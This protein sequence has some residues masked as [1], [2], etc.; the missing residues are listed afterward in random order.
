MNTAI[1]PFR[2]LYVGESVGPDE[3]VH[4]FSPVLVANSL[5]LFQPGNVVV[6]GFTGAGKSMLLNLLSPE[7][8]LAYFESN[9]E[10]P[11]PQQFS[12]FIGAGIN[13]QTS[14]V[15]H[16]GNRIISSDNSLNESP[17]YFG[18]FLNYYVVA[19]VLNS[20]RKLS[21][22]SEISKQ[23]GID[24][25][26]AKTEVFVRKLIGSNC[27][28]DA[29]KA[30]T[31]FEELFEALSNRIATYK[32]FLNIN[33]MELPD[34][35]VKTKTIIG[36]PISV[37]AIMLKEAGILEKD[38]QIF[39]RID[40][41]EELTWLGAKNGLG[42]A[43]K[44]MIHKLLGN[45]DSAVSYRIGTR[46]FAWSEEKTMFG[47]TAPLEKKR[48]YL[49]FH[50]EDEMRRKENART[51]TFPKL[52]EDVF[53]R[54]IATTGFSYSEKKDLL[55][56]VFGR[57]KTPSET[58]LI[59]FAGNKKNKAVDVEK[60]WPLRWKNF[61]VKIAQDD[62]F[63]A[64]LAEAWSRQ[65][66]KEGIMHEIPKENFPWLKVYWKKERTE[67]ALMQLASR[68][69]QQMHWSGKE[70]ILALSGGNIL[71]F[72]SLCQCIWDVWL[73]DNR[74]ETS[75][76]NKIPSIHEAIQ[77]IGI[78]EA[79]TDWYSELAVDERGGRY[80]KNFIT[81]LGTYFFKTLMEDRAMSNPGH[82]GFSVD[83]TDLTNSSFASFLKECSDYG[84]LYDSAHTSKLKDKKKRWKFYLNPMLSP[85]F[86][87]P[88][89]HTKEPIY[90][91]IER[92]AHWLHEAGVP[93]S[94]AVPKLI[95]MSK[96]KT[97]KSK[98][99]SPNQTN[100]K[101]DF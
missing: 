13:L 71:A 52:A 24:L 51:W 32:K 87:I 10:Y 16:F 8:R 54:R 78:I 68:N 65:R 62:P 86:K 5:A 23:I 64:R 59:Y 95:T 81:L 88:Y 79:S 48:N 31:T 69:Q 2:Q 20:I 57:T 47:T 70:D 35:I 25:T 39:V 7:I 84:D 100:L 80:R 55:K 93:I 37:T 73:R 11:I 76:S 63:E 98:T 41:Y 85:Y 12:K 9:Q 96:S 6:K 60:E 15:S 56:Y 58:S 4:L 3:F 53:R 67:Q 82:N 50:L 45:R 33:L 99:T 92:L 43:Y 83:L 38:V 72:L 74:F 97:A 90:I 46:H 22:N 77:S 61:L 44:K 28:F 49:E 18:D 91:S 14:G 40:Q 36:E 26:P 89:V 19:D 29:L 101:F 66:G 75:V 94:E 1:N 17:I 21:G 30:I 42:E 27:W 34:E